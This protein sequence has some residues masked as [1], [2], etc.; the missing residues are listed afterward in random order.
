MR[1]LMEKVIQRLGA[2]VD[3]KIDDPDA[4]IW[5]V[6]RGSIDAVG[7]PTHRYAPENYGLTIRDKSVLL[8]RFLYYALEYVHMQG[9]W[10][11]HATGTTKLVNIKADD[12][13]AVP[14]G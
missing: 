14:I 9:Y 11:G 12:V 8:P 4:D 10:R 5:L 6:R 13:K 1:D 2:F 3:V 7:K